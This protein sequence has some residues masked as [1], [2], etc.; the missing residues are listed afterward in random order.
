MGTVKNIALCRLDLN[1]FHFVITGKLDNCSSLDFV[2]DKHNDKKLFWRGKSLC[3]LCCLQSIMKR[4][5]GRKLRQEEPGGRKWMK[6]SAVGVCSFGQFAFLSTKDSW[7][8]EGVTHNGLRLSTS[9]INQEKVQKTC[10]HAS[11]RDTIP[12][13]RL[14]LSLRLQVYQVGKNKTKHKQ[15]KHSE[16]CLYS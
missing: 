1:F 2:C 8:K 6:Q 15:H 7:S 10:P 3:H 14:L 9:I 13:I 4:S 5:Q 12:Q 16:T 11:L